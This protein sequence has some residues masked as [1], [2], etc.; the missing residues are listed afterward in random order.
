M[1]GGY[2]RGVRGRGGDSELD[3]EY[4]RRVVWHLMQ[5]KGRGLSMQE[6]RVGA[7]ITILTNNY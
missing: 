7:T 3:L 1:G 2:G 5:T 4:E 6:I